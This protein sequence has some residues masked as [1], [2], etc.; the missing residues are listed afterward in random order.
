[1]FVQRFVTKHLEEKLNINCCDLIIFE[2][3]VVKV[4]RNIPDY[5]LTNPK[6]TV[7]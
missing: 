2:D 3:D 1:M 5:F 6:T 7:K 4:V